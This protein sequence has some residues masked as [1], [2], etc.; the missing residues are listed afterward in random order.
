[1]E[2]EIN[3]DKLELKNL[4]K[5][6]NKKQNILKADIID[7]YI[8]VANIMLP[9][10]KNRPFTMLHTPNGDR[11]KTFY[12]KQCPQNAPSFIET[13]TL[14][15]KTK[16]TIDWCLINNTQSLIYMANKSVY[17]M[18]VWHSKL[19]KIQNP[20]YVLID[21]DPPE[22]QFK[23]AVK[24][25]HEFKNILDAININGFVKTS[26]GKGIHIYIPIKAVYTYTQTENFATNLCKIVEEKYPGIATTKRI[27]KDRNGKIY[28]DS[29]QNHAG[30]TIAAPYSIRIRDTINVSMPLLWE[31]LNKDILPSDFTMQMALQ[32]LKNGDIWQNIYK[33]KQILPI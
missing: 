8:N 27:I 13:V 28:L 2:I 4:D 15:S 17:E 22:N 16:N 6:I 7:Y 20:S 10:I 5:I 26:G 23:N 33:N 11:N 1:M 14:E 30:K 24:I 21:I 9:H 31:N 29:L 12:Q 18:H 3:K 19:P 32:M 25:A